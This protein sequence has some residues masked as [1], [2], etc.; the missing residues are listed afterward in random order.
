MKTKRGTA[1]RTSL[2]MTSKVCRMAMGRNDAPWKI[3]P[4]KSPMNIKAKAR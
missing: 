2:S 4:K 1:I 3:K